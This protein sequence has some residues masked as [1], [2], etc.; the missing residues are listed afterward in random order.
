V[1][2]DGELAYTRSYHRP[3]SWYVRTLR[4]ANLIV[5]ALE[6]PQ[7]PDDFLAADPEGVWMRDVPLH[8]LIEAR[9]IH[10]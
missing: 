3:L 4:A 10:L 1:G 9:R 7:A 2:D 5:T 6:E 8:C